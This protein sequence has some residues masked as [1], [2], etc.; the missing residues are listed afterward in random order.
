MQYK[1]IKLFLLSDWT[2]FNLAFHVPCKAGNDFLSAI[3][4]FRSGNL[5]KP[6]LGILKPAG[7]SISEIIKALIQHCQI[8]SLLSSKTKSGIN[9]ISIHSGDVLGHSDEAVHNTRL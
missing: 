6:T 5:D 8:K 1:W 9:F 3:C 2:H 4:L 7:R